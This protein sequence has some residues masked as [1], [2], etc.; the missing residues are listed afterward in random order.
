MKKIIFYYTLFIIAS[1]VF[2]IDLKAQSE[3]IENKGQ[4]NN[5]VRYKLNLHN[6]ALFLEDNCITYNF[7]HPDE[8]KHS[9]AHHGAEGSPKPTVRNAHAYKM[10]FINSLENPEITVKNTSKD[11]NN[12]YIGNDQSKWASQVRKHESV[13]FLNVYDGIDIDFYAQNNSMKYNII[14]KPGAKTT[15]VIFEYEGVDHISIE[16][17]N[18]IISTSVNTVTELKPYSFQILDG[19]T[20][21]ISCKYVLKRNRLSFE[22][23]DTYDKTKDLIIDP[24]LVFSTYS[25]STSDNWGFTATYDYADNVYSGGIVFDIGYPTSTGAYQM[26]FAGGTPP[27][28]GSWYYGVGCDIGIIKY[29]EDGTQK[30]YATYLGGTGG[31]EMPHSLVVTE[32][33]DL[34]IMGTTGSP[35]FPVSSNAFQSNFGGGTSIVYDNVIGFDDGVDIFVTKISADGSQMIGSTYVG[36]SSNDG[37]NYQLHFNHPNPITGINHV[38]MHGND[39]LYY[40]YGDGARGEIMV[41]NKGMVYVGTNTFSN[42]FPAGINPGFQPTNGGQQDGI[43]FKLNQDLSQMLWS[44]YMGGTEDDAIFSL[45][46]TE[47]GHVIVAGG[48][49]SDNFPV[50]AG[51][52]NTMHNG[53]TTDAFVAI[54]NT[55]GNQLL[56]STFFGSN[57]YDNAF[58]VRTDRHNSI[59]ICGQ[60]KASGTTLIQNAAYSVPNSGQF[61]TKF[62]YNLSNV[63]WSTVFGNGNGRPNISITAFAV[64]V[65]D[66]VYLSGWGREWAQNYLNAQGDYY[67]WSD[68]FGTKGL[69]ITSDAI[70]TVTD[71]QDFYVIVLN[72]DASN[73]EYA[74]FFGELHYATC[75]YS[76]RDHVDG[77]TSRFDKKGNIIQSVCASCGGCQ[78]F[79]TEPNPG[80][81][82]TSNNS[83]NCN[84]AVFKIQIIENLAEANFDP[85]PIGCAPYQVQFNNN[86]QGTT[87]QWNFGDGSPTS[88]ALNPNHNY[89]QG[90]EYTVSLIV[91]D[92]ESC[93]FYDTIVRVINVIEPGQTY[94][95][96]IE[97]CPNEN[98]ILGPS[99]MYPP[100]T[101]F[102][103][104]EGSDLNNYNIQNPV[105]SPDETTDYLLIANG[106]CVDSAWQ[107]VVIYQPDID[108]FVSNDTLICEGDN[109]DLFASSTGVVN[110]WQ[111]SSSPSFTNTL[112]NTTNLSVAPS[113][114]TTYYVRAKETVCNTFVTEQ[115]TVSI[116]QFNYYL[117]PE[118]IICPGS[119][120]NLTLTNQN[121]TDQLSYIWSPAAQ[122]LSGA[123]SNSP[124]VG[125][126]ST[127]TFYVTITNQIGCVTN[128]QV[129]VTIDNLMFNSPSVTHNLCFGDCAGGI[130]ISATGIA[131]YSYDWNNGSDGNQISDLCAGIYTVTV[132]DNLGCT[133]ESEIVINQPP[134]LLANFT[135]VVIPECD[136]VGYG[137]AT[138]NTN[139]GTPP[140]TYQWAFGGTQAFNHS[141]LIGNNVVTI[142][143]ANNCKSI[144]SVD[145]PSPGTLVSTLAG[146]SMINCYGQCN[147]SATVAA[148][149]GTPPYTYNWSN[150]EHT[151]EIQNLCVGSYTVTVLDVDNCVSHKYIFIN[152]P[153]TLIT[154]ASIT[155]EILCYGENGDIMLQTSGGT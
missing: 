138:V 34:L 107:R 47:D 70:Q 52:Y 148:D 86:S 142:T 3:F 50:T 115:V 32:S 84:N 133:A 113:T 76:G 146:Y 124:L 73:L 65:C 150:G 151:P 71:G 37:L 96:D 30:L 61:I 116:H 15:D 87:F 42:D 92:P 20:V 75:S 108:I 89:S 68:Q 117:N 13:S 27:I 48:A 55:N 22:I 82:S 83:T 10:N 81:W 24:S 136:G 85:I 134:E 143:D 45:S 26:D 40:N 33:N 57:T 128:N 114:N 132:V 98:T 36:G 94:L 74:S 112:S 102:N 77:G 122:I 38:A 19:D 130:N 131:P 101:T 153:D 60:T 25:G 111:W 135:N 66:R 110:T 53:G 21:E 109:I 17:G 90:G 125:P 35:D 23:I 63:V 29:N 93:N 88:N 120:T 7:T 1:T 59:F 2:A 149:L 155:H 41:D 100:G 119:T 64:D 80:V 152:Q 144:I 123:N 43:V 106:V 9:H 126:S 39:S 51:A 97:I 127:T 91:G 6:G 99:G 79:P 103:W 8:M 141:C 105:A 145:M 12:Y 137:S 154:Q 69:P 104:V 62:N 72:E 28:P 140:Y 129:L 78:E 147:G 139:G 46:L 4:W 54:I 31:Q 95:P 67:T 5:N 11:Y 56:A 18:L 121:S 14:L 118:H 44:S 49:V 58:F 16:N